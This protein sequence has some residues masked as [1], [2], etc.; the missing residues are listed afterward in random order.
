MLERRLRAHGIDAMVTNQCSNYERVHEVLP[1]WFPELAMECPDVVVLNYGGAECQPNIFSTRL[2]K[3][4]QN[5]RVAPPLGAR[6][7]GSR[8][9]DQALR[10]IISITMRR[11]SPV[12]GMRTWRLKPSRF[13]EE[14]ER[15]IKVIRHKTG[16]L[17]LVVTTTPAPQRIEQVLARL[18]DR[19]T[20]FAQIMRTVVDRVADPSVRLVDLYAIVEELGTTEVLYDGFHMT[21]AAHDAL[22]AEMERSIMSWM[23]S[24]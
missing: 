1:K 22:A 20:L 12:L 18:N 13:E 2:L 17:V 24:A 9:F 4:V 10:R 11:L 3:W 21:A 8:A 15:L 16:G 14:L 6:A 7:R 5:R 23:D 19:T